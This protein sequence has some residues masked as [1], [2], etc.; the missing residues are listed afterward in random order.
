MVRDEFPPAWLRERYSVL[1]QRGSAA[2]QRVWGAAA[3]A[4]HRGLRILE[5]AGRKSLDYLRALLWLTNARRYKVPL[6]V[7]G[8]VLLA[9]VFLVIIIEV[10]QRQAAS[11]RGQPG[12]ELKDLPKLENDARTTLIQGLGGLVLLGGLGFTLWNLLLTQDRQITEQYTRAVEQLGS[13]HLAVRLGAIYALERIARDSKRDHWPIMEILTAYV[14]EH[15]PWKEAESRWQ[16][17][18]L[19]SGTQPTPDHLSPPDLGVEIQ[20]ILTVLGRRRRTH[21]RGEDRVLDLRETDLRQASLRGAQLDGA[22]L[23]G[24]HLEGADLAEV[25]LRKANLWGAHLEKAHLWDAHLEG[26]HL[27]GAH[28]E[29]ASLSEAY[30]EG[31][32]LSKA[33]LEETLLLRT[34]LEGANLSNA[35]IKMA[36]LLDARLEGADLTYARLNP[37]YLPGAHLEGANLWGANLEGA[38]LENAHLEGATLL[39]TKLVGAWNLTIEQLSTVEILHAAELDEPLRVQIEQ[40]YSHLLEKPDYWRS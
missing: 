16:G 4:G 11:W 5:D 39:G 40:Q 18:I 17:E 23:L 19:P 15:A 25:H 1:R 35:C 38:D 30:L 21:E 29:G 20:A 26:A 9:A 10:P 27:G 33:H 28:L 22:N 32:Y 34:H 36:S 31:A 13:D 24:A 37:A 8:G 3:P 14:R 2:C 7:V 6:L 12:V